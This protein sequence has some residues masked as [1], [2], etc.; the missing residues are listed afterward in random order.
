[1][2]PKN[3]PELILSSDGELPFDVPVHTERDISLED[4]F[5]FTR[6]DFV[7]N[8]RGT[9]AASQREKI[10]RQIFKHL[11][12]SFILPM[13]LAA[14]LPYVLL[15][16]VADDIDLAMMILLSLTLLMIG[17]LIIM[18]VL[19]KLTDIEMRR[20]VWYVSGRVQKLTNPYRIMIDDKTFR[21]NRQQHE[22]LI[23]G[24]DCFIFYML[25]SHII[26]SIGWVS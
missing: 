17:G 11:P 3:E 4:V 5:H 24:E 21:I 8:W 22:A 1:M 26:L 16:H 10:Q 6:H 9:F 23:E 14:V 19:S 7:S 13:M 25:P 2:Q 15:Y 12:L 18:V 20:G